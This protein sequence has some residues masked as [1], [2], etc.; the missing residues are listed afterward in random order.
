MA[1]RPPLTTALASAPLEPDPEPEPDEPELPEP[2]ELVG[3]EPLD[4]EVELGGAAA[5]R[6]WIGAHLASELEPEGL[7][8]R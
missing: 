4:A 7:K 2:D 6:A 5:A 8:G 3:E 1:T